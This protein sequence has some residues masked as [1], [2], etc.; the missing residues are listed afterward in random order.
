MPIA[1]ATMPAWS[2]GL[3]TPVPFLYAALKWRTAALR[4]VLAAYTAVWVV[5][6]VLLGTTEEH[7]AGSTL[8][9]FLLIAMAAAG[10]THAFALR[11]SSAADRSRTDRLSGGGDQLLT[12]APTYPPP[13]S[14]F[15]TGGSEL[16]RTLTA[17]RA[18]VMANLSRLPAPCAPL[19]DELFAH[20]RQVL[21]YDARG[22]HADSELR[23]VESIL[24]DYLPTSIDTYLRLPRDYAEQQRGSDGATA[25]EQL[26][27]QLGLLRDTAVEAADSMYRDDAVRLQVQTR[28][29]RSKFG[30]SDLDLP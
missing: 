20:V 2:I 21:D 16:E 23:A 12:G 9:G 1:L 13:A 25:A 30:R 10:T 19:L 15:V 22:G 18:R 28:F 7:S 27:E 14:A 5:M 8:T 26:Q 29:L 4:Y 17:I 3:L 11:R 24:T 6:A